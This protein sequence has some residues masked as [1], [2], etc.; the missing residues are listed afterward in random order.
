DLDHDGSP[1]IVIGATVLN[2]DGTLRWS[3]VYNSFGFSTVADLDLDGSAEIVAGAAY[4]SDGS[5]MWTPDGGIGFSAIGN[6]DDD[7]YP[8]IVAVN[9]G[10]AGNVYLLDHN[11]G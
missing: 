11:G 8:E 10:K 5:L 1:E 6:F 7:P 2:A 4:R 3:Q 9:P